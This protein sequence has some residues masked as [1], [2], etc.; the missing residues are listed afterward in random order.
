MKQIPLTQNQFAI[1]D[2]HWFDYL[3]QWKWLARWSKFTKSFYAVRWEGKG[4][5]RKTIRMHRVIMNTPDRMLCDHVNHDTLL[6]TEENLRNVTKAQNNINRKIPTNNTTGVAGVFIRGD[7]GQYRAMLRFQGERVLNK[8]F[9]KFED[10]VQARQ[11][12]E[13]KYFGEYANQNK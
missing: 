12:A 4:Q 6:N 13:K 5:D 3:N 11:E 10:A 8:T 9:V 7:N 2:D 1:V